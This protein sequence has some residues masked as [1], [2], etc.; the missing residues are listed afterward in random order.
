MD[1]EEWNES[2]E[3]T[4]MRSVRIDWTL[5]HRKR[6]LKEGEPR[7]LVFKR[8]RASQSISNGMQFG[9]ANSVMSLKHYTVGPLTI[10]KSWH[11]F[12]EIQDNHWNFDS[13][14]WNKINRFSS[15]IFNYS[16]CE[17]A[18]RT[19]KYWIKVKAESFTGFYFKIFSFWKVFNK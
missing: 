5:Y 17:L 10:C 11:T 19:S 2:T 7:A 15:N 14:I 3:W 18:K 8:D 12:S 13:L 16:F 4:E 1:S 9:S 6:I